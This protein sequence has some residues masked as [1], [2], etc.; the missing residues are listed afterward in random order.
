MSNASYS[1][2]S[3]NVSGAYV[4]KDTSEVEDRDTFQEIQNAWIIPQKCDLSYP[5]I[6][7]LRYKFNH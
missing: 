1:N 6:N 7:S 5:N 3:H 4:N 2:S